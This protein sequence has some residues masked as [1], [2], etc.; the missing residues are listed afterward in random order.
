MSVA[1]TLF[2]LVLA[3]SSAPAV[4]DAPKKPKAEEIAQA[5][6]DKY[7]AFFNK[8]ADAIIANKDN[9]QRM[10]SAINTIVDANQDIIKKV[11][12]AQSAG[13]KLPKALEE[14]MA[15]RTREMIPAMNKCGADPEVK[16]AIKR[17]D[18]GKPSEKPPAKSK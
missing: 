11:A 16:A 3:S 9:C 4:A 8:L 14:K 1:R 10:A 7:F 13:K 15:A 12:E 18:T 2:V 17:I 5:D 6:A